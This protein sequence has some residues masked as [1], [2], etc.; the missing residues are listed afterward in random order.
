MSDETRTPQAE[1]GP[2][3]DVAL[4]D[5]GRQLFVLARVGLLPGKILDRQRS[6]ADLGMLLD[7]AS[8]SPVPREK[9]QA[10]VTLVIKAANSLGDGPLGESVRKL[11]G[12]DRGEQ[13][14]PYRRRH[15]S[16]SFA[17]DP[18]IDVPSYDRRHRRTGINALEHRILEIKRE[19]E[20]SALQAALTQTF[21]PPSVL[22]D[23][24]RPNLEFK[25][26][27]FSA[28]THILGGSQHPAFT[29]WRYRDIA[30][31]GQQQHFRIFTQ[32][33]AK[34]SIEPLDDSITVE[35]SLGAN[36][37]GYQIWLIRFNDTPERGQEI[38]WGVRKTF[39]SPRL[40]PTDKDWLSLAASQPNCITKGDFTVNLTEADELPERFARFI[41][42]KMT[43]PNLRGPIWP[44]PQAD[45]LRRTASFEYLTPWHSHGIYWWWTS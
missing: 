10:L 36:R 31:T 40:D 41:T 26:L 3:T 19:D 21:A 25:R 4:D 37:F 24:D 5:V 6:E 16:A 9:A 44:L 22:P 17:W 34:L 23:H 11:Y 14:L 35:R 18:D 45:N 38:E 20:R 8:S 27:S 1:P 33:E 12:T 28:E 13:G 2:T 42:P 30:L 32:V 43:L 39:S 29:D 7:L 15:A